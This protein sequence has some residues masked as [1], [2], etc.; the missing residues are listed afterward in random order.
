MTGPIIGSDFLSFYN[1]LVDLRHRRLIDKITTLTVNG[2]TVETYDDHINALVG[3]SRSHTTLLDFPEIILPAGVPREPG[4]SSIHHIRT[5]P[6]PAVASR[7]RQLAPVLLRIAKS[8]FEE[9]LRSGIA[10]RSDSPWVSP[11]YLVPKKE[12]GWRPCG[13]YRVLNARTAPD[14]YPFRHIADFAHQ[15]AGRKVFSTIDLLKA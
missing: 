15:L 8:E 1:L 13:D 5:M 2:A 6:G 10:R 7:P 12:D 14:Q 3:S 11:L 4:H 9:M